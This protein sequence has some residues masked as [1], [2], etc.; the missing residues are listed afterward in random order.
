[1]VKYLKKMKYKNAP[2]A[3]G[4]RGDKKISDHFARGLDK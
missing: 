1:V 4:I 2:Q 3:L